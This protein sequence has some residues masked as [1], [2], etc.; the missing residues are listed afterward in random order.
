MVC[1]CFGP[2][3]DD[4]HGCR[5]SWQAY[6][7][8]TGRKS[9]VTSFHENR[10]NN[11][12]QA[13]ASVHFHRQEIQDCISNFLAKVNKKIDSVLADNGSD[14]IDCHII[15]LGLLYFRITGPY[16][17]LLGKSLATRRFPSFRPRAPPPP[18]LFPDIPFTYDANILQSL[19]DI[20]EE[21]KVAVKSLLQKVCAGMVR[22][23]ERQL[24]DFLPEGKYFSV[25]DPLL[26]DKLKHSHITNLLSEKC[27][28]DLDFSQFKRRSASL[29]HHSTVNMLKRNMSMSSW[30]LHKSAEEQKDL[31]QLSGKK[32]ASL[33]EKHAQMQRDAVRK[34]RDQL[35]ENRR[36]KQAAEEKERQRVIAVMEDLR[37]HQG[38][39]SSPADIDR[40]IQQ[41]TTNGRLKKALRA[42]ILFQKLVLL[43]KSPLLKVTGSA[44]SVVNRLLEL[45]GGPALQRLPPLRPHPQQRDIPANKRPRRPVHGDDSF[46]DAET[47]LEEG[48]NAA[49]DASDAE[50]GQAVELDYRQF[51]FKFQQ[52]GELVA[53]Y[54]EDDFFIAGK[55]GS[56]W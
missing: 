39:C 43:K 29:H 11:L 9:A 55:D 24:A 46:S 51:S 13:A 4:Q 12:F 50:E 1:D 19:L 16:W 18:P 3:G 37:P 22:V 21:K 5:D 17:S 32:A 34:R 49:S 31:L 7:L 10:F 44:L 26:R 6:C 35:L 25:Q 40:L 41:Y 52:V 27:F 48:V 30:F 8:M 47:D 45:F 15:T 53:V 20:D 33:R 54:Y 2:R 42:E 56:D 14:V 38:P 28:A 23:T 36:K